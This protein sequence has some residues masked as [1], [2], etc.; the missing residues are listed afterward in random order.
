MPWKNGNPPLYHVWRSMI[1][2]CYNEKGK[3]YHDYGG[4][5]IKVC[6]QWRH[7]YAQWFKD[8]GPRP[9]GT[10]LDRYPDNDG[11]YEPTNCRWATKK[12][13]QRN[14]RVTR[15][16]IIEGKE[17][18]AADLRDKYG[19]KTDTIVE[20]ANKGLPFELVVKKGHLSEYKDTCRRGHPYTPENTKILSNGK[21]TCRE[22]LHLC[23]M[24]L[25]HGGSVRKQR[26]F[27]LE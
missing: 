7:D 6:R 4:R 12:Q 8:M 19:V 14:Q 11:N 22:C 13:Q 21:R 25:K 1:D 24:I 18:I 10:S 15:R 20:R 2:R 5:G 9:P 3:Q 17:Y 26:P 27:K 23:E 16:V